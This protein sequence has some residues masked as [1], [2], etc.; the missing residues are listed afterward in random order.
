MLELRTQPDDASVMLL[1]PAGV[2]RDRTDR[3]LFAR[4]DA[5]DRRAREQLIERFLPLARS[6]ARRYERPGEPLDD[7]VQVA[8][9]ALVKAVDR[10]DPELGNAFTSFAVPTIVG[11]LKRYFRDRTWAV[12]PPRA[13]QELTVRVDRAAVR[14]SQ[15]F[16]RAPTVAQLSA[17]TGDSP[18]QVL[19][20]MQA[21]AGRRGL[22][23]EAPAGRDEDALALQDTLGVSDDGYA[24]VEDRAD[25]GGLLA[26]LSPRDRMVVR[27]R[28]EE[29]LT[30]SEIGALLGV[31]QMQ[32]S[33]IVRHA[34][35][36]L[37]Y[38]ADQQQRL[39]GA[40]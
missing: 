28:F 39:V 13:V 36:Q 12:R 26:Y 29:D 27:L 35:D 25:L 38:I 10:F 3:M 4:R 23:L 16:D 6:V 9:L 14:L 24:T 32:I 17:A 31:S 34:I 8:S 20:A 33:R 2:A 7:L 5:G 22:S 11:E 1:A 30:Q 18:E 21:R 19:E 37:R 40:R 15:Q